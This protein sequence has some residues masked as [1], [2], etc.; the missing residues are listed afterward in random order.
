LPYLTVVALP[1]LCAAATIAAFAGRSPTLP[2]PTVQLG[3][4]PAPLPYRGIRTVAE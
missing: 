3:Q 1:P 4:A 2:A